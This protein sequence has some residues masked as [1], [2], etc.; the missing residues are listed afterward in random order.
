MKLTNGVL[1]CLAGALCAAL[2]LDTLAQSFPTKPIRIIVPFPPGGV[3]VAIRLIQN[4]MSEELGQPVVIENRAG[5]NGFIGSELVA[6]SAPDGYTILAT[7]SST[8]IAGPL[9][10]T[11]VPFDTLRD[12]T[13]ITMIYMTVSVLAAKQ[14]LAANSVKELIDFA[15][16]NPGKLSYGSSGIGS[17]QHLDGETFKLASGTNIV[18][19]PYKGG[20]PQAQAGADHR[21][22]AT[23]ISNEAHQPPD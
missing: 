5:A 17:A 18:H 9:V 13:P 8:L 23:L 12:F 21:E 14:S 19:V 10:S 15:R 16:R 4:P 20:G 22:I 2:P 11:N 6:R 7:S 1:L 3:D